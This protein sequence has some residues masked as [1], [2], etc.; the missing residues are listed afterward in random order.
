MSTIMW[1]HGVG[2]HRVSDRC[3]CPDLQ[4]AVLPQWLKLTPV[5]LAQLPLLVGALDCPDVASR[6][7]LTLE[8]D[9]PVQSQPAR[10]WHEEA[11][12]QKKK[13]VSSRGHGV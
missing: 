8:I 6:R 1:K 7:E 5:E 3:E 11:G 9:V 4:Q 10:R 2:V 13:K 12:R